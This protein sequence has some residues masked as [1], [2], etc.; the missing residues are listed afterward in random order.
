MRS[1]TPR[2]AGR[3]PVMD[4]LYYRCSSIGEDM[5]INIAID[6]GSL[7]RMRDMPIVLQCACGATHEMTVAQL[8]QREPKLPPLPLRVGGINA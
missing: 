5:P 4:Q 1:G 6:P 3:S 8:F 7:T 2:L